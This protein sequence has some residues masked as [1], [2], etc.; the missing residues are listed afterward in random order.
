MYIKTDI[1]IKSKRSVCGMLKRKVRNIY[2]FHALLFTRLPEITGKNG[3]SQNANFV[4]AF[5]DT[6]LEVIFFDFSIKRA[7]IDSQ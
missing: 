5:C 7:D 2:A 6:P 3:V 4:F 1:R